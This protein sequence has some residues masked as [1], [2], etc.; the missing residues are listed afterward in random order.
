[1]SPYNLHQHHT[2]IKSESPPLAISS[3]GHPYSQYSDTTTSLF[4]FGTKE[5][6][7]SAP[8]PPFSFI[9]RPR[10]SSISPHSVMS[11]INAYSPTVSVSQS[12]FSVPPADELTPTDEYDDGDEGGDF[13]SASGSSSKDK[14][15][16]RRSSKG[17][18]RYCLP[19]FDFTDHG[20][21]K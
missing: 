19:S 6:Q 18:P 14:A 3:I 1:M 15:V 21:R 9:S 20:A 7:H 13:P 11:H 12:H 17:A 10:S 8:L 2:V 5:Q 16:R 4:R